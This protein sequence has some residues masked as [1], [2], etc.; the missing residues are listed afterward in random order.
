VSVKY[1]GLYRQVTL[2]EF[3]LRPATMTAGATHSKPTLSLSELDA[4]DMELMT[5]VLS[6]A[7]ALVEADAQAANVLLATAKLYFNSESVPC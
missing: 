2:T 7:V 6:T 4:L 3:M 1:L 5:S